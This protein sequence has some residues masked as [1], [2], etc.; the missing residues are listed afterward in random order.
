MNDIPEYVVDVVAILAIAFIVVK[1]SPSST[2]IAAIATIALGKK[3][4]NRKA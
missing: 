1:G 2:A 4:L 3:Y